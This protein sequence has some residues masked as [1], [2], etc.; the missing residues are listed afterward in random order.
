M[1]A[2]EPASLPVDSG[3]RGLAAYLT[4]TFMLFCGVLLWLT[5][6][7]RTYHSLLAILLAI[8]SWVTSNLGGFYIGILISL[9]GGALAFAW[10]TDSDYGSHGWLRGRPVIRVPSWP[11]DAVSRLAAGLW[12]QAGRRHFAAVTFW[13]RTSTKLSAAVKRSLHRGASA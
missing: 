12:R 2:S 11:L 1:L 10:M 3:I 5:S 7:G 9:V 8:D 4:P 13:A 6:I